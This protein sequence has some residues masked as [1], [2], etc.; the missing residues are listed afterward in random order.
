[1]K[2][3]LMLTLLLVG[4]VDYGPIQRTQVTVIDKLHYIAYTSTSIMPCGKS[5][6]P[7]TTYHPSKWYIRVV[8]RSVI[9]ND[10]WTTD[11]EVSHES[12]DS[13][14]VND[15]LFVDFRADRSSDHIRIESYS[16]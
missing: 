11:F 6:I 10:G 8:R 7:I 3:V 16:K 4:C 15:D 1:M 12:F 5:F 2:R 9:E 14:N 13:I